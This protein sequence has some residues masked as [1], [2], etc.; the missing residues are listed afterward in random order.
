VS[1]IREYLEKKAGEQEAKRAE[2]AAYWKAKRDAA[3]ARGEEWAIR[4]QAS[5]DRLRARLEASRR[6]R[7]IEER[8]RI[9]Y[10]LALRDGMPGRPRKELREA[11]DLVADILAKER[12]LGTQWGRKAKAIRAYAREHDIDED[13]AKQR[14]KRAKRLLARQRK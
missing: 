7:E 5:D 13:A 2:A 12:R 10:L 6:E 11:E 14:L 9:K 3:I 1:R 4:A 8:D